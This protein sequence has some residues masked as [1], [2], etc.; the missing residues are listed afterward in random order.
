MF[1]PYCSKLNTKVLESRSISNRIRR[2]RECIE[3]NNRFTTYEE[4]VIHLKVIK[5]DNR[6]QEFDVKKVERSIERAC[7]KISGE[8][9]QELTRRIEQKLLSKKN[10][11]LKSSEIGKTILQELRRFD[12]VAYL[13]FASVYKSLDDPEQIKKELNTII[14]R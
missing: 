5:K 11:T 13:R 8:K 10:D 2:R 14:K 4:A 9:I 3:C 7:G 1:C 6:E 12:T